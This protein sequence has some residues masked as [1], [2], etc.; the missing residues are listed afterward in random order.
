MKKTMLGGLLAFAS[1]LLLNACTLGTKTYPN[2]PVKGVVEDGSKETFLKV[3]NATVWLIPAADVAAMGK[4]P[5]E[6]RKNARNDEPLEDNLAANRDRYLNAK[7]NGNGEFS[8][9]DVP[10]GKYFVYVEPANDTYLPGGDKSRIALGTDELG[11]APLLIKISGN[12]PANATYIGSTKCIEC[13]EE[14]QHFTK[15]LHRLGISVIGK[16]GKLQDYS[17]FPDFNKGLNKL[18]AGTKFW[19]HGYDKTRSFDKYQIST[20]APADASSVSFTATFYKDSDGILKFRSENARDPKDPPRIYPVEM[21]Y[22]GGVYKQRYLVRVGAN[23]FPFVQFNQDGDDAYADR[24]RKQ[25]RDYHADWFFNEETRKLANPPQAKSFDKECAS[26]H[27]NGYSLTK[28]A[29]GDYIAGSANDFKGEIDI[30]GNGKLNEI[31]IGCETCHG[32]G[33]AHDKAKEIDMPATIVSPNKLAAERASMICGQCHSRPQGHLKNDQPVNAANRMMLPGTSRNEF[34]NQFTTR[35][36]A[37]P[38]DYW[39]DQLHSKSHHQQYTDFIKSSK[40]RNGN[41]LVACSDCH[42]THDAKFP[43]QLKADSS[44]PES[45]TNCHKGN[46]DLKKHLAD[47]SKCTVAPEKITCSDCHNTKTMQTGAGF[48]KG[49]IGKDGKNYWMN[50]ITSHLYDVPRKDNKG[51]KDVESGKAMPIPYTK[52]CGAA[53]HDTKNF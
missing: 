37:A 49:L 17:R 8:F 26:C 48:G 22:G 1:I 39:P 16:P 12:I 27:Y 15:T 41:R 35:E 43:H 52:A 50:D 44:K 24:S 14:Q 29:A 9:A 7:T 18:M 33:S 13:H 47:K 36:D 20:K 25:W 5:I 38:K 21:T 32:P 34:L 4:T 45:C 19:F 10:G 46:T 3:P 6:I 28:T 42:D 2:T 30:D 31:N 40:Y 53:C 51:V 11:A 23:L